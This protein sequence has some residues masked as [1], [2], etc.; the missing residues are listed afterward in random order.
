MKCE[1][2]FKT[3]K[4]KHKAENRVTVVKGPQSWESFY[5]CPECTGSLQDHPDYK[6]HEIVVEKIICREE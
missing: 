4:E 6:K 2:L 1:N 5:L 3:H